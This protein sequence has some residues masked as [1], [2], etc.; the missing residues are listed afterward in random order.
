MNGSST[1]LIDPTE[2][3][4][5]SS[6]LLGSSNGSHSS[7]RRGTSKI[8]KVYTQASNLYLTRRLS[9]ALSIIEPLITF[10]PLSEER[11]DDGD[12]V[13]S[14][15]IATANRKERIKVWSLYL[16]LLNAIAE[17]GPEEGK[18]AFGN[19]QWKILV[20]KAQE[21]TIWDDVVSIGYHG[22]EGNVD[23]DVVINLA[24]L[25]LAQ[26]PTQISN[27]ERLESYLSAS[28][29]PTLDL[30]D[31]FQ[32]SEPPNGNSNG[33]THRKN[34]T[35]TP[36]DLNT[37]TKLI[38]LFT[39]HV[40]PKNGECAYARGFIKSSEVL[41]EEVKETFLDALQSLEYEEEGNEGPEDFKDALPQQAY[42]TEQ[43]PTPAEDTERESIDTIRQ[44]PPTQHH[45]SNSENDYG[46]DAA[47]AEDSNLTSP[48]PKPTIKPSRNSQRKPARS[49]PSD[50]PR[51]PSNNSIYKRSLA[52]MSAVQHMI[53]RMTE[54]MAQNPMGLLR[55]VLFL[56]G[57]IVAFSR[58]DVKDRLGRFT[59]A[60]WDKVK[61]T[62]GMGV[63]VSYI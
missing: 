22:I 39:L 35:N 33:R 55:F 6:R 59:G 29:N 9:E 4:L 51:K 48:T 13:T 20:A 58:R 40:L 7:S 14:A 45:R 60:G 27:Q 57:L 5:S 49:S 43:D 18:T 63:K 62:I 21:G 36:Q 30:S 24:T 12:R 10:A 50:Y 42:L 32:Q 46:I 19:K 61:S 56:M 1:A 8:S 54:H 25:L 34:G 37:R 53:S 16:T 17:L 31:R 23:A 41:D 2:E 3:V 28:S 11:T 38:E 47:P 44:Q 26:S 52:L 15:P